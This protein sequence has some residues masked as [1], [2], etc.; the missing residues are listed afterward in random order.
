MLGR[1]ED[2]YAQLANVS[3]DIAHELRTPV[4][5]LI[6]QTEVAVGQARSAEEY[7][8]ILYSNLEEFGRLN[9]M[10]NDMLF[11]AQ[12]ENAP[13][14]LRLETLNLTETIQ[15]LFE[16][17]EDRKSTRLN[18]SHV[19]ISYAVFCLKKKTDRDN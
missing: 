8:E 7:R 11:L 12:T 10:V 6:T 14:N 15:G 9:R 16:Y 2:G 3:A 4:T 19:A 13:D 5:N 17:F 1:I 18:S